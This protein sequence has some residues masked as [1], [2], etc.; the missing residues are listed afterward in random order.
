MT[1]GGETSLAV[2]NPPN[3]KTAERWSAR[4]ARAVI[5]RTSTKR[6]MAQRFECVAGTTVSSLGSSAVL[7]K[8]YLASPISRSRCFGSFVKQRRSSCRIEGGVFVGKSFQLGSARTTA[9]KVSVSVSPVN[10]FL[11]ESISNNT[12]PNAQMSARLSTGL[13]FACSDSCRRRCQES[14]LCELL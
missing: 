4:C 2:T 13:P 6:G 8:S 3:E 12:A 7:S 11:P 9:A 1:L 5:K 10:A 14:R